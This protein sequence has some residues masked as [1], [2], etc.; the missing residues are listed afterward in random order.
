MT[1]VWRGYRGEGIVL[2]LVAL[3]ALVVV[4]KPNAQ[5]IS[6]LALTQ[7]VA[8]DGTLT[9]DRYA[10]LTI[11]KALYGGHVYTDKAPGLSFAALVPY[12]GWRGVEWVS[13][14]TGEQRDLWEGGTRLWSVR[15]LTVGAFFLLAVFLVGRAAEALAAGTGALTAVAFGLG[16]HAHPVAT[17]SFGHD[18]AAALAVGSFLL[19][20]FGGASR[21]SAL[22]FTAGG[23]VA[24]LA[25]LAEYQAAVA[26]A[27]LLGYAAYR[28]GSARTTSPPSTPRSTFHTAT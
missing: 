2:A 27:V 1:L 20:W 22:A 13:P 24:G 5:D 15:L 14:G 16:T 12:A 18:I 10:D 4:N 21:R 17:I 19:V 26:A 11:D 6:R 23:I 7:S 28:W 8:E 3:T 9:I 25:V